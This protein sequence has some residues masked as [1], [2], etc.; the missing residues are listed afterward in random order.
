MLAFYVIWAK[1]DS[2]EHSSFVDFS[3]IIK[4]FQ[5]K[6]VSVINSQ[7]LFLMDQLLYNMMLQFTSLF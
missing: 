4:R 1:S 5:L 6:S 3:E 2:S 7:L